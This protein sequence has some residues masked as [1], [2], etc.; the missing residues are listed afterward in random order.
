MSARLTRTLG[1]C[2]ALLG[3]ATLWAGPAAHA[4]QAAEIERG[5]RLFVSACS[6]CHGDRGQG[7]ELA[8]GIANVGAAAADFQLR[9]GRMPLADPGAQAVRKPPAFSADEIDALVAYVASLGP[10]P[11]IP[12]VDPSAG[13]LAAGQQLFASNC[14]PCHGATAGGGAVGEGALAPSLMGSQPL[15]VAEAVVS[16]PGQMPVFGFTEQERN[17]IVAYVRDIQ[18]RRDPGGADIGGVGPVPEGY[19]A[20]ALGTV[21]VVLVSVFIGGRGGPHEGAGS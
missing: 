5:R 12:A 16:G 8:P 6:S 18:T 3:A 10:G 13:D 20:W 11:E 1:C 21:A 2:A 7:T 19:V 15:D 9:T 17:S 4:R 14:A